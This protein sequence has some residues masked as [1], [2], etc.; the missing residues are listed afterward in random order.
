MKR[1]KNQHQ[2]RAPPTP[3]T[4]RTRSIC[5]SIPASPSILMCNKPS[6]FKKDTQPLKQKE[7]YG[8]QSFDELSLSEFAF[9]INSQNMQNILLG[10]IDNQSLNVNNVELANLIRNQIQV[11]R[12]TIQR[13]EQQMLEA[14]SQMN[15]ME[16][17]CSKQVQ[18]IL[19][20][21]KL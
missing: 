4:I 17:L 18:M 8:N 19:I 3:I 20:L 11:L 6:Q 13:L 10:F 12:V 2:L 15:S 21:K 9:E 5:V 1:I 14:T 16:L 7:D